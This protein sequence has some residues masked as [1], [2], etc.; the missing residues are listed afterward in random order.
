MTNIIDGGTITAASRQWAARPADERFTSL[1]AMQAK[2]DH[3]RE[4]SAARVV[5]TRALEVRPLAEDPRGLVV[6]GPSGAPVAPTNWAFGQ[7]AQRA[8]APAAYMRNLPAPLAA[9]C[10]N[11][12]LRS[13]PIAETGVLLY[14]NGGPAELRAVTGPN[15]GRV[16]NADI[17][18]ALRGRFGDGSHG[19]FSRPWGVR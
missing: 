19:R 5:S 2:L 3:S 11:Y 7:L 10:L 8:G 13:R 15:Y 9:D 16:W 17:V 18:R 14:K 4:W 6:C 1:D 12:G